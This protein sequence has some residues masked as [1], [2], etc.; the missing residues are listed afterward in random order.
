MPL[1]AT[2]PLSIGQI[3]RRTGVS[4]SAIRFYEDKGL[5]QPSRNA[6]GQRRFKRADVRRISFILIAQQLGLT[7]REIR[8]ALA[9]LP[10]SRTPN[11]A[12]WGRISAGLRDRLDQQI[13]TLTRMRG[14]LDSCIGCGCLS[15]KACQLYNPQDRLS[16]L[17]AGPHMGIKD[18]D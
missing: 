13:D 8:D 2:D 14:R 12:D 17:G 1:A 5:V 18:A 10:D 11:Q 3:A 9:A 4:V 6:G 7:I 15:L 16:R